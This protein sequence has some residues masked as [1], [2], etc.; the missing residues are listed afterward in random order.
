M[1]KCIAI[2]LE[3][4]LPSGFLN[5][6]VLKSARECRIEGVAHKIG[7]N[8]IKILACGTVETIDDFLD[9]LHKDLS[10]IEIQNFDVLPFLKD[11]D[12][13]GVFRIIE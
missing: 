7:K 1:N 5:N 12:Y 2:T 11:K 10:S 8:T 4:N 13:R 6:K 9:I 3:G